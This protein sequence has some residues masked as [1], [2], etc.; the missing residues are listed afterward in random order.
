MDKTTVEI[1]M[2]LR[3]NISESS[4]AA[5][6]DVS[7]LRQTVE[8]TANVM[9]EK[10]AESANHTA[11]TINRAQSSMN[12]LGNSMKTG[13]NGLNAATGKFN[14]LNMS[15]QQIVRELP[16]AT[17]GANMFFLAIS[18]NLPILSDSI[19]FAQEQNKVMQAMGQTTVPV[20]R[21]VIGSIFSWQSA[22]MVGITVLTMFGGKLVDWITKL[23]VSKSAMKEQ[24]FMQRTMTSAMMDGAKQAA[25]QKAKLDLLYKAT[26]DQTS[27][28]K[29]RKS[30]VKELQDQY[31]A[32]F[33]NLDQETIL[34]GNAAG[35][36]R[37]LASDLTKVAMARAYEKRVEKLAERQAQL[38]IYKNANDNYFKHN[39][40]KKNEAERKKQQMKQD[41]KSIT[42][43]VTAGFTEGGMAQQVV[44]EV[45]E[46]VVTEWKK[47]VKTQKGIIKELARN[48][49]MIELMQA[50]AIEWNPARQKVENTGDYRVN[51]NIN[52]EDNKDIDRLSA[53][54]AA[55]QQRIE[56]NK[57]ALLKDGY[58]KERAIAMQN[59]KE[60]EARITDE[61]NKRR[62]L[63]TKLRKNGVNVT[64]AQETEIGTSAALQRQQN[65]AMYYKSIQDITRKEQE[66]GIQKQ[67]DEQRNLDK[68]LDKYQAYGAKRLKIEQT[69]S[70]DVS[71]LNSK[72]NISNAKEIDSAIIEA[73]K[74]KEKA[75]KDIT[76]QELDEM[77]GSASVMVE[78]FENSSEKSM[79]DIERLLEKL[80]TLKAYMDAMA[81][82]Q[83]DTAG[84]ATIKDKTGKV[85]RTIKATDIAAMGIT[86][87]QLK[88]LQE[89]PESLKSFMDKWD[90]LK[91]KVESY[92]PF[93]AL[94]NAI[95]DLLA[96]DGTDKSAKEK[97]VKKLA[98]TAASVAV[99]IGH[100][101]E[102]LA[103]AFEQAGN[104]RMADMMDD[105]GTVMGSVSN[106]AKGFSE[107]GIVG[108]V[109]A[110]ISTGISLFG[111]AAAANARHRAAMRQIMADTIAQQREY[112]LLLM[113]ESLAYEQGTT[114]FGADRYGKAVNAIGVLKKST[115]D[116]A[117]A[118]R[119]LG[120]IE[121][122]TGHKKTGLF[123]WGRGKDLYSSIL[124]VYPNLVQANGE[125]N[126]SLAETILSSRKMSDEHKAAL[127]NMI[128]LA[129]EQKEAWKEVSD[130][131]NTIF[132]ELGN[133]MT[134]AL[135]DAF[136]NGTDAGKT[137][138]NS[139]GKMLEKLGSDM[140][141]SAVLQR[142]F[143]KAQAEIDKIAKDDSLDEQ[144]KF[145][146]YA[147][148][149]D[150]LTSDVARDSG[151][152][153]ELLAQFQRA[154]K[155]RGLDIYGKG[156][157]GQTGRGNSLETLTQAQGTKLE[158]LMTSAQIHLSSMDKQLEDVSANMGKALDTLGRIEEHVSHCKKLD[159][160]A[161]TMDDLKRN[162]IK[163]K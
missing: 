132:G 100:V 10:L 16:S 148:I 62:N 81:H 93:K 105:I 64:P 106:I 52:H 76:N 7:K 50:K 117:K 65:L 44:G 94:K 156:G 160:I 39:R 20:W 71:K 136:R 124:Q 47:R 45:E 133:T 101:A 70:E 2:L 128:N 91:E 51:T 41:V 35:A 118:Q 29:E 63:V 53:M 162:G 8:Q 37:Q 68:L 108:G 61:E 157:T 88:R 85:K 141:Y 43:G 30:A 131:F 57:I 83:V 154:A 159:D 109:M 155:E 149:L 33:G 14:S 138:V 26:Q 104:Q 77:K 97:K 12:G 125:F 126:T 110:T 32:Y 28:L 96:D 24:V 151:K 48:E 74:A 103:N 15:V 31:P 6:Q 5:S 163:V 23:G 80:K 13:S 82:D 1:E 134:D 140:V 4:K 99:E 145:A 11:S 75:L 36:Y 144:V 130:Y 78:L 147:N 79:H 102:G 135:V 66:A 143:T 40:E 92:N 67:K 69:Y 84:T 87:E 158:G 95:D 150:T 73:G 86:P 38:E 22:M 152:V 90:E 19:R 137:F 115:F 59:Y 56:A 116:L 113:K 58:E 129:K 46:P 3:N 153:S 139:V 112:N 60:E 25:S 127:Q 55:A 120:K 142:Y 114:A 107:G 18:N 89:S 98:N 121:I 119:E 111:K 122:V 161:E 34:V 21:Q 17:M 9:D 72:R 146:N 42:E 123:G 49:K 27:S 54:E